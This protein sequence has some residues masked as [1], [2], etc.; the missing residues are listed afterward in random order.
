M[1]GSTC[2]RRLNEF[3]PWEHVEGLD[4]YGQ[5]DACT[6]C[7]SL[8]PETLMKRIEAGDVEL[9]PTDKNYKL[10]VINSGGAAF[11]QSYRTDD[12]RTGDRSKWIWATREMSQVKFYFQHFDEDQKKRFV[13]LLSEKKLRIQHPG[14]FYRLPFFCVAL[15]AD[16]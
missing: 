2:P 13:D 7:G 10:Y 3:G 12:D 4:G 6:F 5:D 11:A 8:N 16:N 9:G 15:K 14:H 1:P